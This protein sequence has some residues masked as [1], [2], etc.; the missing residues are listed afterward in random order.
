MSAQKLDYVPSSPNK[1][2]LTQADSIKGSVASKAVRS[3][4]KKFHY[5]KMLKKLGIEGATIEQILKT[6]QTAMLSPVVAGSTMYL[7]VAGL[8]MLTN[9]Y[10]QTQQTQKQK[11][12]NSD[13][14][15]V[16]NLITAS[17]PP[18][19]SQ[20]FGFGATA[21]TGGGT[22]NPLTIDFYALKGV[23]LVYIAS[24]GNL[25][26]LLGSVSGF[27]KSGASSGTTT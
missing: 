5:E 2:H 1:H 15:S 9:S 20:A 24:G 25:A 7:V 27:L 26:G 14:S 17:L 19:L 12:F 22:G 6:F 16:L 13:V 4:K 11:D 8:E 21:A 23:I 10:Y 18:G 3:M